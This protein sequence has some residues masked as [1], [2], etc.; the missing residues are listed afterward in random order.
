MLKKIRFLFYICV[1]PILYA[2]K[3]VYLH[4]NFF[5]DIVFLSMN[6]SA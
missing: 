2:L 1:S 4:C 6:E 3:F 5:N